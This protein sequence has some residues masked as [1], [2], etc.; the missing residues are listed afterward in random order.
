M[1]LGIQPPPPQQTLACSHTKSWWQIRQMSGMNCSHKSRCEQTFLWGVLSPHAQGTHSVYL[2]CS[3]VGFPDFEWKVYG[4][5]EGWE[6]T[7]FVS[8]WLGRKGSRSDLGVCAHTHTYSPV[9]RTHLNWDT[10]AAVCL[11]PSVSQRG[12]L[13][14]LSF[15]AYFAFLMLG[16]LEHIFSQT[17]TWCIC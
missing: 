8:C 13:P 2:Q 11:S 3:A 1:E 15:N 9:P 10:P 5:R 17:S 16:F 12:C 4:T 7:P 6:Q 14:P